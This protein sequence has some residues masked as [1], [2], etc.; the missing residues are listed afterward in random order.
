MNANIE[1][2]KFALNDVVT[3]SGEIDDCLHLDPEDV[4]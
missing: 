3:T 1:I 2:V 4:E